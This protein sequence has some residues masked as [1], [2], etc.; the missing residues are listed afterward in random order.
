[1]AD[2]P[3]H[4]HDHDRDR[5]RDDGVVDHDISRPILSAAAFIFGSGAFS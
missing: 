3:D 1:M 5:D 4:D 2:H